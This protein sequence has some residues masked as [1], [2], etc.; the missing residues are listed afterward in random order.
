MEVAILAAAKTHKRSLRKKASVPARVR[1]V[2]QRT[3]RS[4]P[5]RSPAI[6][7]TTEPSAPI[8]LAMAKVSLMG[9]KPSP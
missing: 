9:A 7:T 3:G 5:Q 4:R 2:P 6:T 8:Q 1:A